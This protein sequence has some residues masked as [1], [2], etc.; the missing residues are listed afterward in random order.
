MTVAA[1]P[2]LVAGETT[3]VGN[4]AAAVL[5]AD[6]PTRRNRVCMECERT[7]VGWEGPPARGGRP[8][9]WGEMPMDRM[10]DDVNSSSSGLQCMSSTRTCRLLR[11]LLKLH[12]AFRSTQKQIFD[13]NDSPC[14]PG[15]RR[16]SSSSP[17]FSATDV[18][19]VELSYT[20]Y[21]TL[22]TACNT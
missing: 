11:E 8:V 19:D 4:A 1:V 15:R 20:M 2:V 13:M 9:C 12:A 17:F 14:L 21:A 7:W 22:S 16:P 18:E 5:G 10:I 3:F 6:A